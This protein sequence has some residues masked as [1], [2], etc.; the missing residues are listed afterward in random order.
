MMLDCTADAQTPMHSA[1]Y[2]FSGHF[3]S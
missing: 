2:H 3:V 1:C